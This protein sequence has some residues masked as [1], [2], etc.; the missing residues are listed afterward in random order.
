MSQDKREEIIH[1][2]YIP[3]YINSETGEKYKL[4]LEEK[5]PK[6]LKI[7]LKSKKGEEA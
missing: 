5:Q 4:A 6:N 2:P 1:V 7:K 3:F